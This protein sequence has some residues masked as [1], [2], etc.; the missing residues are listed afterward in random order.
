M[1][2]AALAT[3]FDGTLA[4]EGQVAPAT[5]AALEGLVASGRQA[6]LVT[7]REL[8]ELQ[9]IFPR[10]DLFARVVAENGAL[11]YRPLTKE[12]A[13]LAPPPPDGLVQRLRSAGVARL[14]VGRGI[15]A[16][17]VPHDREVLTAIRDLG[18]EMQI[19]FNKGAVMVLPSGVNKATGLAAALREL[20]LSPH[21]VVAIG[22][23]ENDLAFLGTS[24]CAVAVANALPSV[25]K[26]ADWVT[27]GAR[28]KGVEETIARLI[29]SDMVDLPLSRTADIVLGHTADERAITL[30]WRGARV[31]IAGTSGGGKTTTLTAIVEQVRDRGLQMIVLDPEAEYE[32][33]S[34]LVTLGDA[35][36]P[37]TM[38]TVVELLSTPDQ[39]L[40]VNLLAVPLT[41]RPDFLAQL[42]PQ[43][44]ELRRKTGRPHWVVLDEAHHVLPAHWPHAIHSLP[45]SDQGMVLVTLEPEL[46]APQA[47]EFLDLVVGV[48]DIAPDVIKQV[49]AQRALDPPVIPAVALQRG[50]A[51]VWRPGELQ[52]HCI[53][54]TR[55]RALHRRHV[56]KYIEGHLAPEGSFYFRGPDNRLN[57]R[58]D[59]LQIFL[60]MAEG[61]DDATWL[62]HLRSG[63]F[64]RWFEA[65]IKNPDLAAESKEIEADET[66]SA[67]E[68]RERIRTAIERRYIV[69]GG[70]QVVPAPSG[71]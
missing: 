39:S 43:M 31:L 2:F 47:L 46:L 30:P 40:A 55:S 26:E 64:S 45:R 17:W 16:T 71:T 65:D 18:L 34:D 3:D 69:S 44:E 23:A 33:M 36:L 9:A 49:A 13:P 68:S 48:G 70:P 51:L 59:N 35:K 57:L 19:V 42:M 15:V 67:Q 24:G 50:Q 25:K 22:D 53:N 8:P 10:L 28:G 1:F 29:E 60:Q 32:G 38:G 58:A 21:N 54:V 7:G 63:D 56:R 27:G 11:L 62:H 6:I 14:S 4:T 37:P 12:E 5:I 41:D 66:L 52:A 20:G 61:V